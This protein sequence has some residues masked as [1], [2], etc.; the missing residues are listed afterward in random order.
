M[1]LTILRIENEIVNCQ[2]DNGSII[3]IARRWF[4]G[5]VKEG[6]TV[7]FDINDSKEKK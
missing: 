6:D 2:L 5:D 1:Q 3:D 7:E 4:N